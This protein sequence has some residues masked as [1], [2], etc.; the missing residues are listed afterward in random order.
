MVAPAHRTV[1]FLDM[2]DST[3]LYEAIGDVAAEHT[4]RRAVNLCARQIQGAGGAVVKTTGDGLLAV[5]DDAAAAL[6][7]AQQIQIELLKHKLSGMAI[8]VHGGPVLAVDG[9]LYG[10]VVNV[11]AGLCS[12]ALAGE[13]L[14]TTETAKSVPAAVY[15]N[16]QDMDNFFVKGRR[17]PV[18]V[19][20]VH[21]NRSNDETAF[22]HLEKHAASQSLQIEAGGRSYLVDLQKT[23]LTVGRADADILIQDRMVSRRHAIIRY[24]SRRFVLT[25]LSLNGTFIRYDTAQEVFARRESVDIVGAGA[26]GFGNPTDV[27]ETRVL[28]RFC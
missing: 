10:D 21:W 5:F 14:A 6:E 13:I 26:I 15:A 11:A 24:T 18:H 12:L 25:D 23:E 17:E 2:R 7:G 28:F 4:L 9:D 3:R 8:A 19:V 27:P 22:H 16:V 1:M 20:K